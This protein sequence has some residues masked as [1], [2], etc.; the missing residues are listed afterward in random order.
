MWNA[1]WMTLGLSVLGSPEANLFDAVLLTRGGD[2]GLVEQTAATVLTQEWKRRLGTDLGNLK[3]AP[4]NRPVVVL[5]SDPKAV[6]GCPG[7][8]VERW[9]RLGPEGFLLHWDL[10]QKGPHRLW[11]LGKGPEG[12]LFGVGHFL[13]HAQI[14]LPSQKL[15]LD[16]GAIVA[17]SPAYPLRGH[18]LGYRPRANSWDGWTEAQF[19]QHIRELALFGTN[20]IEN[21]PFQDN[22]VSP[23][24]VV[25]RERMNV[26]MSEICARYGMK[27]WLWIPAEFDLQDAAKRAEFLEKN[28]R[29]YDACPRVD[30][31][32]VPG[33]DPGENHPRLVLPFCADLA[34][35]LR[36]RHSHA[37]VWLSLQGYN[38][39][40]ADFVYEWIQTHQPDWFGGIVAGPSSPPI[41]D[42]RKRLS[43]RY[44]VRQ[45]PDI[46]H[47]VRCQYPVPWWDP[48]FAVTL[49]REPINPRPT[50]QTLIH[51]W[52][53]PHS[54]GFIS[55]SDGVHDDVN[56]II[57]SRLGW[58]PGLKPRDILIEYTRFFLHPAVAEKAADGILALE[59]NWEGPLAENGS[60]DATLA[61]WQSLEQ[62][63]PQLRDNWRFQ[64]CLIRAYYDAYTRHR[65]LRET[66]LEDEANQILGTASVIGANPSI[67]RALKTLARAD[68][69][70]TKSDYRNRIVEL[71]DDLFRSIKLQ[72]SVEKYG[73][74]GSERGCILDFLDQ[75]LN[76]RWWMED[77]LAAI[78][79]SPDGPE[80]IAQLERIRTW[81][82][83]GPGSFYDAVGHPGKSLHVVRGE[84]MNTD[85]LMLRNPNPG[86]SWWDKGKNRRRLTWMTNMDWPIALR[87]ENLDPKGSY[88][89]RMTGYRD[90]LL[91]LDGEPAKATL[92][93]KGF[94]EFKEYPVE[95]K[96]L[97]DGKLTL[98]WDTPEESH[99]NWREQSRVTEVWLI[100]QR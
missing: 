75:P 60:V 41:E 100:K 10:R 62:G 4:Q 68:E 16:E 51:N 23:H 52:F 43:P 28:T 38:K 31:V 34:S 55:Y 22:T 70:T 37:K 84:G 96:H 58:D 17:T 53:A 30:G 3:V 65:L 56:K 67:D 11:I 81:E 88:L 78:R 15:T 87:Y 39:E 18:Q 20:A 66:Q 13:R 61:L 29:L 32:F 73:A 94:G 85:P 63:Q 97:A 90:S 27:Y 2:A 86:H 5:T 92:Y 24:Q 82:K 57:W 21:I 35:R 14:D 49:G 93:G 79:K 48:A 54:V 99:L 12:T 91:R 36:K 77:Q 74:S 6:P 25:S 46:T 19:D 69:H 83:P 1:L 9:G 47:T 80:K 44:G 26:A 8:A 40:K 42:S 76:N 64:M 98:T 89:V 33:G 59:K 45:Y 95:S 50:H 72:T 71:C 7:E